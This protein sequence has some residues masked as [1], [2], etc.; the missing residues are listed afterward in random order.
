MHLDYTQRAMVCT[1]DLAKKICS[2]ILSLPPI[3]QLALLNLYT[4]G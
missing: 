4:R 1:A 3:P 2:Q